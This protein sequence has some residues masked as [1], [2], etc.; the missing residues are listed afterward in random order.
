MKSIDQLKKEAAEYAA[1]HF[2]KSGMLIGLGVG[3]TAIHATRRI[4][5]LIKDNQITS[6][7]AIA[8]SKDTEETAISLGIP[9][10]DF[11]PDTRIDVTID[12][13]DE[14]DK[15]FNLIKGGGGALTREKIVAQISKREIIVI[16]SSKLSEQL[17]SNWPIP[18][19][20]IPFGWKTQEK[21]L[22]SLGAQTQLR[23]ME[24]RDPFIT[25]QS[26]FIIDA[27]FGPIAEPIL[28]ADEMKRRTGIVEHG[29]FVRL[30]TDV[31]IAYD[32][33]IIH[34]IYEA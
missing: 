25:D 10:I 5:Q 8:C 19:E 4:A 14:V 34:K 28:L 7:T 30:A 20:V 31:I 33:G 22:Q 21:Y 32:T 26:N 17:G 9:L 18:V 6:I 23:R 1:D 12:G 15:K 3:S 13:A 29:L 11:R 27:D 2:I 24:N 16:D